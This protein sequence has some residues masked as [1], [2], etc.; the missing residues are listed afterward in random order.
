MRRIGLAEPEALAF[1]RELLR[2][3]QDTFIFADVRSQIWVAASDEEWL[4]AIAVMRGWP[5]APVL[6]GSVRPLHRGHLT[7]YVSEW[8]HFFVN[9]FWVRPL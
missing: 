1:R 2:R 5:P 4:E 6:T 7:R 3:G 9:E 8:E